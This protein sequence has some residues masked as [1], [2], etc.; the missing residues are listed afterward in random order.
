MRALATIFAFAVI[1]AFAWAAPG[2]LN[3]GKIPAPA[4]PLAQPWRD[5]EPGLSLGTFLVNE[6][7]GASTATLHVLRIDPGKF[8]LKLLNAS[9]PGEGST[10]TAKEWCTRHGLVACINAAM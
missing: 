10:R 2:V 8:R 4:T 7:N 1:A 3:N 9:A 6:S 5:L